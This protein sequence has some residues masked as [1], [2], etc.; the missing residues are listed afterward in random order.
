[1][2][3]EPDSAMPASF[4]SA[5][6]LRQ[7]PSKGP[8]PALTLDRIVAA[9]VRVAVSE[10]L[11]AVSMGR[12][13]AELGTSAM[14][15]YRYVAAK[16]ELLDLM[17]DATFSAPPSVPAAEGGWRAGLSRWAWAILAS[18]RRNPWVLRVPITSPP[19]TPNQ[20]AWMEYGLASLRDTGLDEGAKLSVMLLVSGYVRNDATLGASLAEAWQESAAVQEMMMAY[21][22]LLA[23]VT[24]P[25]R[26]PAITALIASGVMDG[27]DDPDD[28]FAFGLE[29]VL[30]G[31]AAL[32]DQRAV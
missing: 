1:M 13:A 3:T 15:L 22:K 17:V 23:R 4:E 26:F 5:W 7:R 27:P 20:V 14:S 10:G 11:G 25:E 18:F 8:K 19:I 31:V 28:E 16:N 2:E 21:P 30:D 12:V 6:G 29:R 9:G 32:V 24:D